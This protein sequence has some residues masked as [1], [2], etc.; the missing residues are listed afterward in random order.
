[1]L[2]SSLAVQKSVG[3]L[4]QAEGIDGLWRSLPSLDRGGDSAAVVLYLPSRALWP[5]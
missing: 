3:L 2:M 5:L 4:G 1:M